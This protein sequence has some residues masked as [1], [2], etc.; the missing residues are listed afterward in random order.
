MQL[1]ILVAVICALSQ[2]EAAGEPA[3]HALWR[4]ALTLAGT[5][6]APLAAAV[7]SLQL[8]REISGGQSLRE[9][10][11]ARWARLQGVVVFLWLAM[12][13][14]TMYLVEWPRVVRS[15]W[16]LGAWPLVDELLVL[17][18][19]VAPLLLLWTAFYRLQWTAQAALARQVG[20][21]PPRSRI[22]SNLWMHVRHDLGLVLAPALIVI[23][24][25]ESL[26][27]WWPQA[28]APSNAW[29]LY[30]PLLG[31]MLLFMPVAVRLVWRTT[32]LAAGPLR[33][34]LVA[35]CRQERAGVREIL[36]WNTAG[37][38]ANAAVA[39]LV[40]GLRYVFLT[41]ALLARLTDDQVAA[42]VRHELG[43]VRGRHLPLRLLVLA[44]P[45]AVWMAASHAFPAATAAIG[46]GLAQC[47]IPAALQMSLLLPAGLAA[48]AMVVVGRYSRWLEHEADLATCVSLSGVVDPAAADD[49]ELALRKVAG[50]GRESRL[51]QWLHP[52]AADRIG[53]LR[54]V[55]LDPRLAT[56][57][58]RRLC[59]AAIVIVAA[60]I[61][62][63]LLLVLGN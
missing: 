35:L 34:R 58:R 5:L 63:A 37:H 2:G 49:F 40:R 62:A 20:A 8:L 48:Y 38:S 44:W 27:W 50:S 7:G 57:F 36:V 31:A 41:D 14:A 45:L 51:V 25:Q 18:P 21:A 17:T 4:A 32:P 42:V 55:A 10:C 29:W 60:Y 16:A 12:V 56:Q 1:A 61:A 23:A 11:E 22:W 59:L 3:G 43:H 30:V 46:T 15:D 28:L 52:A 54:A 33:E 24:A 9:R 6:V 26:L 19:V 13:A 39:G 47:G 53:F